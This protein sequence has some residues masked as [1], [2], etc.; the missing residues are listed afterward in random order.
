MTGKIMGSGI[1]G[2][3]GVI[4]IIMGWLVWKKE[5]INLFHDYHINKVSPENKADFCKQSGIGLIVIGVSLLITALILALTD[6]ALS[7]ICFAAGFI[8]G[9]TALIT[10][11]MKYNR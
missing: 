8:V 10:A 9:L 2:L 1:T 11:G 6:S 4:I 3:V 7:F 5:K